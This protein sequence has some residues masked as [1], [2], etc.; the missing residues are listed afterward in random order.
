MCSLP[1]AQTALILIDIPCLPLQAWGSEGLLQS[2][3]EWFTW[4]K[5]EPLYREKKEGATNSLPEPQAGDLAKQLGQDG[6]GLF[7]LVTRLCLS[8]ALKSGMGQAD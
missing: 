3:R 8:G 7:L 5:L 6:D 4:H 1:L 2:W